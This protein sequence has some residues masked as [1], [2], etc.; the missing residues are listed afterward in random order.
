MKENV[1][2]DKSFKFAIRI[3]NFYKYLI[4]KKE[5]IISK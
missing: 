2:R 3:I 5:Y 4:R 1:V